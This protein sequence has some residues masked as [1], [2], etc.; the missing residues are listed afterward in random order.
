MNQP[1]EDIVPE[2]KTPLYKRA[3]ALYN[4]AMQKQ[5]LKDVPPFAAV[6]A[7]VRSLWLMQAGA[8]D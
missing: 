5:S 6:S 4:E 8:P 1:V 7:E 2:H 3:E